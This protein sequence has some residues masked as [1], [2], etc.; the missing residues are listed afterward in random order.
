MVWLWEVWSEVEEGRRVRVT[1][2]LQRS[3]SQLLR[4]R[5][6][7]VSALGQPLVWGAHHCW[8]LIRTLSTA[9]CLGP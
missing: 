3:Q 1:L 2:P 8:S 9:L 6:G 7:Q 5:T 4:H